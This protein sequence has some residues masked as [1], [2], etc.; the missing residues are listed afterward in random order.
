MVAKASAGDS[1]PRLLDG[2]DSL[3]VVPL[4][5]LPRLAVEDD[6][7]DAVAREGAGTWL[8]GGDAWVVGDDVTA[9]LGL[10]VGVYDRA[11]LL[12]DNL[13]VPPPSLGVDW[14]SDGPENSQA[15]QVV[16]VGRLIPE[17]HETPDRRRRGV[18]NVDLVPLN[19]VPVPSLVRVHWGRLEHERGDSVEEG[20][21][22]NVGVTC[23]PTCVGDAGEDVAVL[24]AEG[25]L[26]RLLRVQAVPS[27][28]V[29]DSLRSTS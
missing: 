7:V 8:H 10:P 26:A 6:G 21:V 27:N 17:P 24:E 16:P 1:G 5:L 20:T 29:N 25:V 11:L 2:E 15:A 19:A 14:F 12:S 18:E 4:N 22:D 3:D 13:V 28:G 9:G 23:D